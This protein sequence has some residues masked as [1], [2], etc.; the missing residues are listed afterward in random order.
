[1]FAPVCGDEQA[2]Y[3]SFTAAKLRPEYRLLEE[4]K[5]F[6]DVKGGKFHILIRLI[7]GLDP[8]EDALQL[9]AKFLCFLLT[10]L[11]HCSPLSESHDESLGLIMASVYRR[12]CDCSK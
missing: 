3:R 4:A 5:V 7:I 9:A 6:L 2:L 1:M 8:G 11:V 12:Q 10:T